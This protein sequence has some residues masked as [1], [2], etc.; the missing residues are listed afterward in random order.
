[1]LREDIWTGLNFNNKTHYSSRTILLHWDEENLWSLVLRQALS[2]SPTFATIVRQ[3]SA[4]ELAHLDVS[5]QLDTLRKGLYLLWGERM[6]RVK[7]S[8]TYNW[9]RKRISDYNDNCFPRSL[10]LLLQHAVEIEKSTYDKNLYDAADKNLYDAV[11]RPNSLIGALPEVSKERVND[12]KNEYSELA[13]YMDLLATDRSPIY[14]RHLE[15]IWKVDTSTLKILVS[16]MIAA[17]ILQEY[18][19][20]LATPES[21]IRYSVAELYLSGLKMTRLGQH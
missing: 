21:D 20:R 13:N 6:G 11:L 15:V 10:I 9:V 12:V 4:I 7:K 1:L 8:F 18:R 14:E 2:T 16:S 5:L 17:G 3:Q 19:S